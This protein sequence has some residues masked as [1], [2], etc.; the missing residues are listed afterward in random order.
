MNSDDILSRLQKVFD[1]VFVRP[2]RITPQLTAKELEEWDSI[3]HI[4]L[5]IA[6]EHEFAIRFRLGEV[7]TI[8]DVGEFATRIEEHIKK[9]G[10]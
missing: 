2:V 6:V 7:A 5:V 8:K 1:R 4:S 3:L 10:Q 9:K